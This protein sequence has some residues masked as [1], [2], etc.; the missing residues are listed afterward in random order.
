MPNGTFVGEPPDASARRDR[1]RLLGLDD[2]PL[3]VFLGSL[4]PPNEEAAAF[5]CTE[6]APSAT[7][8]Q[9]CDLRWSGERDRPVLTCQT[10]DRQRA[11]HGSR[12]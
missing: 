6:L 3:A 12:G 8:R 11:D 7:G 1:K 4:Y 2:K 5:I 9:L 10:R